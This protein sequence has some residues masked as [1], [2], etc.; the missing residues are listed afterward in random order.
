MP[1]KLRTAGTDTRRDTQVPKVPTYDQF[2]VQPSDAALPRF[3]APDMPIVAG[4]D[5]TAVGEGMMKLGNAASHY[6]E[7]MQAEANQLRVIDATNEAVKAQL[8]LTYDKD[9]GFLNFKGKAALERPDNKPLD[10]E[11]TEKFENQLAIIEEKLGNDQQKKLF[12]QASASLTRQFMGS[13]NSHVAAEYKEFQTATLNGSIDVATQKM[14]MNWGDPNVVAEQQN[15][16]KAAQA[17]RDKNLPPEQREANLVK[18]LSPGNTAVISAAVDAGN[19]TYAKEYLLQNAQYITPENRLVLAKAVETGDFEA[20]TQKIAQDIYK[21][22]NGDLTTALKIARERT[23]GKEE[24]RTVERLKILVAE[25]EAKKTKDLELSTQK[26]AQDIFKEAKG[27]NAKALELARE[28]KTGKEQDRL[29]ERLKVLFAE[30]K[31]PPSAKKVQ[32]EAE[33]FLAASK[34]DVKDALALARNELEGEL[35]NSVVQKITQMD[36]ETVALRER[37]Q[38]EAK[39]AGYAAYNKAGS[40]SKI[41]ATVLSAM[42]PTDRASLQVFAE[43][44]A[45]TQTLRGEA[46]ERRHNEKLYRTAAPE[47]LKLYSDVEKLEKMS[48]TDIILLEPKMGLQHVQ[49]LLNRREQLQNREGRLTAKMDDDQFKAIATEYGFNA[50]KPTA[51]QKEVLGLLQSRVDMMLEDAAKK[52]RG[53]LSKEEKAAIMKDAMKQEVEIDGFFF[54]STK[55]ALTLTPAEEAKVI[56]PAGERKI[57]VETLRELYNTNKSAEYAPTEENIRKLYIRGLRK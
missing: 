32:T 14:T 39:E 7:K 31:E 15:L 45:Y 13:V 27:D 26:L 20:R 33:R 21:E 10:V 42:D 5:A 28:R 1:A 50:Y 46:A 11:F 25:D 24:D 22:S 41:P 4:K 16:I 23:S 2:T 43:N 19:T 8:A 38:R 49:T 51:K 55:P 17:E 52:K 9:N 18:A 48:P 12:R 30:A 56:V 34:G 37:R 47:F 54:N 35:E 6:A 53:P 40:F 29:V 44:R 36:T 3:S 57:I